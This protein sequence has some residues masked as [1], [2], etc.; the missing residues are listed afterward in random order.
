[1]LSHVYRN[2]QVGS[3]SLDPGF[4][5]AHSSTTIPCQLMLTVDSFSSYI[6][7]LVKDL[8]AGKLVMKTNTIIPGKASIL[9][10]LIKKHVAIVSLCRITIGFPDM[11]HCQ[12]YRHDKIHKK[13]EHKISTKA[14]GQHTCTF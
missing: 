1:M 4:I 12:H 11:I 3:V 5:R 8:Q 13:K 10:G 2:S 6:G 14:V 9:G 7:W